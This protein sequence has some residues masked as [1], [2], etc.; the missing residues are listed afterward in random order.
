MNHEQATTDQSDV[1][2]SRNVSN[3]K[4]LSKEHYIEL[5]AF[6]DSIYDRGKKIERFLSETTGKLVVERLILVSLTIILFDDSK[7]S[8]NLFRSN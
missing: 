7:I 3:A 2:P 6:C 4:K 1:E 5:A 8:R